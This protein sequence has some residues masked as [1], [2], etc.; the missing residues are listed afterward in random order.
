MSCCDWISSKIK[1][2]N[3]GFL[4][5]SKIKGHN[6]HTHTLKHANT[7]LNNKNLKQ[8][9]NVRDVDAGDDDAICHYEQ[10]K[11]SEGSCN[12]LSKY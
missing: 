8:N 12:I 10:W 3:D 11:S 7:Q 2:T 1:S 4:F 6:S 9:I 5:N